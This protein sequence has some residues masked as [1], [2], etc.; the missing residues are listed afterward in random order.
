MQ[1]WPERGPDRPAERPATRSAPE[2]PTGCHKAVLEEEQERIRIGLEAEA[3]KKVTRAR[4]LADGR[5][6]RELWK[7]RGTRPVAPDYR[8]PDRREAVREGSRTRRDRER[9]PNE[10]RIPFEQRKLGA[11]EDLAVYRTVSFRDLS[12]ARFG[13]NDFAARRAVSQLQ[14]EK[15]VVRGRGWGPKGRPFLVLAATPS[16]SRA[17]ARRGQA[18]QRRWSGLVKPAESHHDTA[19][20]RAARKR[21]AALEAEG[22][23]IRRIRIDAELKSELARAAETARASGGSRSAKEAQHAKAR[24]L[25]MPVEGG[26]VHVPDVQLEYEPREEPEREAGRD[27]GRANIEV[28]TASYK[29]G[30]IRAK[31]ALGFELAASG[32]A[33]AGRIAAALGNGRGGN[34]SNSASRGGRIDLGETDGR[35]GIGRQSE[36]FEI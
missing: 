32:L 16:G 34:R 4:R 3:N 31:A 25:G 36:E 22:F 19:V 11:L 18:D 21:I 26:K 13:G 17:A 23:R 14:A 24:E 9:D 35:G 30:S 6:R 10:R 1:R 27:P 28:V 33:A 12:D 15:L 7:Q 29:E 5:A 2:Q 20:Y 8:R